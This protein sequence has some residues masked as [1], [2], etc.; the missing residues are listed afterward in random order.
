MEN[1]WKNCGKDY[2]KTAEERDKYRQ[3]LEKQWK[4]MGKLWKN[5]K[6]WRTIGKTAEKIW[7]TVEERDKCGKPLGKLSKNCGKWSFNRGRT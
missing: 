5:V 2:G 1:H 3:P 6:I 4:N 7:K